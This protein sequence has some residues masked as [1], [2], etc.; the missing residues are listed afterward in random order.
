VTE[1]D[2]P[3]DTL[4]GLACAEGGWGYAPGQ[5]PH[6]EPTCLAL[7][8]L[9]GQ[10]K[11]Y[12]AVIAAAE[13]WLRQCSA[14]DGTYRLGRGRH[15]AAWPTALV[16]Y[17][18][19]E[20]GAPREELEAGGRALL[21]L[22]G[23]HAEIEE[24]EEIND[25]DASLVGWPWAEGNFS[26]IE[27]TAWACLAL[28]RLG[29]GDHPRVQEGRKLLL[30]RVLE[31]GGVNYGNRRIFGVSLEPIPTPTALALLAL[32]GTNDERIAR[33]ADYLREHALH[34][35]DLEHLGWAVLALD[36]CGRSRSNPSPQPPPRSGEGEPEGRD[37]SPQ[38]PPRS[39]E[40]E[41]EW[42]IPILQ[43]RVLDAGKL[44]A[45]TPYVQAAPLR[46]ALLALALDVERRNPF[47]LPAAPVAQAALSP[48]KLAT[49]QRSLGER[50]RAFAQ[51]LAVTATTHLRPVDTP[52]PVHIAPVSDYNANI[53]DVVRRQYE[54]FRTKVPLKGKR[55]VLKPNLVEYHR[56]KVINTHPHLIAAVIELCRREEAAEVIVAEGPGHWRNVEY[57]VAASGLGDVL[58]HYKVGFVDLNHDEPV[59]RI[60]L[61]RLT[62]LEH[63]YLSRTVAS[64]EVLISLPKLKTHHWAV[65]T[66]SLKNLFGTLP[67]ICYGW[68]KNELHWRGIDNSIVDIALTR[69]PD[70]A[71]VDGIIGMEGDGPLNGTPKH[72][73]VVIM[74]SDL[75]AVDATC[76]R[77]MKL[78]PEKVAYLVMGNRKKLGALAEGQIQQLGEAIAQRAQAF[79]TVEHFRA[80]W[81]GRSA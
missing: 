37:P 7:L 42:N 8:A 61:G 66:L 13:A 41:P 51:G 63:L 10:R 50:F 16:L 56:D 49:P 6:I 14:G 30:D 43:K 39:G 44:R 21:A 29:Q 2:L 1:L 11:R 45:T 4:A 64:A 52:A 47:R 71:I 77:L 69:T 65:A 80:V 72:T 36:V 3:L 25:I 62:K 26:W 18:L 32:Q 53:A 78:D 59:R 79:E 38:P 27:P 74:G 22:R 54:S 70:L 60:N 17:T 67:G 76:C 34:A 48:G 40:G 57:L 9:A 73:G 31:G 33:S 20:L 75:V 35:E 68:P 24:K 58:R 55:V 12:A 19:A 81:M 23:R 28:T 15:E 46:Q 5:P